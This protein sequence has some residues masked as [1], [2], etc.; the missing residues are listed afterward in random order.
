MQN[1]ILG[2]YAENDGKQWFSELGMSFKWII[3][4]EITPSL[5]YHTPKIYRKK[6]HCPIEQIHTKTP[7]EKEKEEIIKL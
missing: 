4:R 2:A 3:Y 7:K 5:Q 1:K 6:N